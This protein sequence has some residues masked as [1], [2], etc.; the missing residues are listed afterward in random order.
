KLIIP[1]F[2]EAIN[3]MK[4]KVSRNTFD[5]YSGSVNVIINAITEKKFSRMMAANFTRAHAK[6][7]LEWIKKDREWSAHSYNKNLSYLRS[8]FHEIIEAEQA[9]INPFREIKNLKIQ[10]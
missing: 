9:Q 2:E 5:A 10:K 8:V 6:Q 1:A 7:C 3:R 4:S